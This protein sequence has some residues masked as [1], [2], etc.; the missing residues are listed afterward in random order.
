M[1]NKTTDK[2]A[3]PSAI[4]CALN[5]NARRLTFAAV[6]AISVFLT[7]GTAV[8]QN[9]STYSYIDCERGTYRFSGTSFEEWKAELRTWDP[10]CFQGERTARNGLT[11]TSSCEITDDAVRANV[12][13]VGIGTDTYL[14]S[15][16]NGRMEF[17][18]AG[19]RERYLY[20]CRRTENPDTGARAF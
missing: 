10:Y 9:I 13:V 18:S 5:M 6:S 16:S 14:I 12:T 7:A 8:A 1:R 17:L 2:R 20:T 15:R 11:M 19:T 4:D 3:Y